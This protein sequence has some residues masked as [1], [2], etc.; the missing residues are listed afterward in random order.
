MNRFLRNEYTF[1]SFGQSCCYLSM[2]EIS[3]I[4][5]C[6]NCARCDIRRGAVGALGG[7][8]KPA[9]ELRLQEKREGYVVH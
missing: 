2:L 7:G 3:R 6:F 5:E 9:L 1:V 4:Q 8:I